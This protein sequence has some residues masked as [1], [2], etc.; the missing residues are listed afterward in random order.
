MARNVSRCERVPGST[1]PVLR[2]HT[3]RKFLNFRTETRTHLLLFC[4]TVRPPVLDLFALCSASYR[5]RLARPFTADLE[6]LNALKTWKVRIFSIY[7]VLQL[8]DPQ[9]TL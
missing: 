8:L 3:S 9:C 4:N 1:H 7:I 5:Y 6:R 2:Q